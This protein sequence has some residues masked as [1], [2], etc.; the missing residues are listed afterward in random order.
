M[1]GLDQN[2]SGGEGEGGQILLRKISLIKLWH[3]ID[4]KMHSEFI[5]VTVCVLKSMIY[6]IRKVEPKSL[7]NGL[8]V[9]EQ[10][11]KR[12]KDDS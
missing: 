1:S 8:G 9:E 10:G 3:A 4:C 5:D 2:V 11:K 12:S 7:A 6:G